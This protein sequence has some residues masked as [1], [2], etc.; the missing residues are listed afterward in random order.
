MAVR[1]RWQPPYLLEERKQVQ[2]ENIIRYQLG[3]VNEPLDVSLR[4]E[5]ENLTWKVDAAS[6]KPAGA[7]LAAESRGRVVAAL[8]AKGKPVH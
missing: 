3:D 4:F 8:R 5:E 6:D 1:I 2:W 7:S